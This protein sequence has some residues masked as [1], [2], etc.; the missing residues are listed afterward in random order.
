M[1]QTFTHLTDELIE[2]IRDQQMYFVASA[3]L[4]AT[5][6]VNVSPKGLDSFAILNAQQVAYLD[7]GGSGI[8]TYAH[9]QENSRITFMFCA[10]KG[11]ANIVR[12]HGQARAFAFDHFEFTKL[13]P[14]FSYQGQ[15]RAIIVADVH[16]ISDSCGWG[17][18]L[19]EYVGQRMQL[20]RFVEN[21]TP[22]DWAQ[23]VYASNH[24]SIDGLVGVRKSSD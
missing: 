11:K 17:V 16:R 9:V 7:V 18:P 22:E 21:Y 5:G 6:H 4:S 8:E 24:T 2:F 10:F 13:R 12:L 23:K 1:A 3:P 19:Y 15:A 20:S 14:L